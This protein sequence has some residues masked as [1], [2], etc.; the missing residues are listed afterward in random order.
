MSNVKLYEKKDGYVECSLCPHRCQLRSGEAGKCSVRK[1]DGD[2][3]YLS[4]YGELVSVAIN[5]IEKKPFYHFLPGTK[6][7]SIGSLGCPLNC[8]YCENHK[9]SQT[10]TH[11]DSQVFSADK[12]A[13]IAI[14]KHCKSVCMTFNEPTISF[15][16]LMD[17]AEACHKSNLKFI[18][19]TN[20]YVNKE[21]WE[22]ICK[23]TDAIN[24][25]LKAGTS[26]SFKFITNYRFLN[27]VVYRIH[28]AYASDAHMEI[29]IPLYYSDEVLGEQVKEIGKF[30]SSIDKDI[31]CHLLKVLPAYNYDDFVF[32]PKNMDKAQEILSNYMNNIFVE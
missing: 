16:Y 7:L 17:V 6:T 8:L 3:I 12:I 29:S 26:D 18:L 10:D 24:I 31:P 9:I 4:N 25:D 28:E 5:P 30:L 20:A 21:P 2:S 23:V 22:E 11:H 14:E 32:N 27:Q 19:K 1:C 13:C 15:E